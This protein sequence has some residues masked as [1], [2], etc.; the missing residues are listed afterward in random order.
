MTS[1]NDPAPAAGRV[2]DQFAKHLNEG[3]LDALVRLYEPDA[4][5]V[6]EPGVVLQGV[7]AIRGALEGFL[8]L[9][10]VISG[11]VQSVVES[12]GVALVV[13]RWRLEGTSPDGDPVE[14]SGMSADVVRRQPDGSWRVL[15]DDP[16]GGGLPVARGAS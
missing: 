12:G 11:Q 8:A 5:F 14:M 16:W 7:D 6:P 15:I 4:A 10:P 2:I 9:E 1:R 13:N 3:D